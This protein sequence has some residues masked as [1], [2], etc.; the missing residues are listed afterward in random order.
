MSFPAW[1]VPTVTSTGA[2]AVAVLRIEQARLE[3]RRQHKDVAAE[4]KRYRKKTK[5]WQELINRRISALE[6]DIA[7]PKLIE[8]IRQTSKDSDSDPPPS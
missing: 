2:I 8:T 3:N 7:L 4:L 6:H 1:I 5:Q